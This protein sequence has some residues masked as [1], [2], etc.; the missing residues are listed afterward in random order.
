[1]SIPV[2]FSMVTDNNG[3]NGFVL[4][5]STNQ[6]SANLTANT[7][8]TLTA[9]SDSAQWVAIFAIEPGAKV[10]YAKNTTATVPAGA[11]F[12]ATDSEL[13][14]TA[15]LIKGG[16]VINLLADGSSA[17]VGVTLYAL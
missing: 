1:M 16:D 3:R 2:Q 10:W 17:S 15:R 12:A 9:P 11:S 6:Y 7:N 13:N 5:S 4:P 8:T 14:P